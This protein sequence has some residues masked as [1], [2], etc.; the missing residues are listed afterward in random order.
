MRVWV[1]QSTG[2]DIKLF[3]TKKA[4]FE[5]AK[6]QGCKYSKKENDFY[7]DNDRREQGDY[8]F[9]YYSRVIIN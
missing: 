5:F 3:K 1:L 4:L 2:Y 8:T 7:R 6:K 9:I